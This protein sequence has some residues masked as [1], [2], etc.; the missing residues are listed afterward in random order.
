MHTSGHSINKTRLASS[1]PAEKKRLKREF[2]KNSNADVTGMSI[3]DVFE[4]TRECLQTPKIW[5]AF[6]D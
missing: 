4:G 3:R 1:R 6:R 5:E 2:L